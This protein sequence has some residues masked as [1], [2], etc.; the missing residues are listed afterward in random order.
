MRN[1]LAAVNF[2]LGLVG[3]V[4]LGRIATHKPSTT[5]QVADAIEEVKEEIK[6]KVKA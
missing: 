4:Q 6:D 2:F 3:L 5:E 1:S